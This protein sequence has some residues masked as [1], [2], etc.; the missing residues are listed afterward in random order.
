MWLGKDNQ[1]Q[2]DSSYGL[3]L[4]GKVNYGKLIFRMNYME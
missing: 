1:G 2:E 4:E 3:L